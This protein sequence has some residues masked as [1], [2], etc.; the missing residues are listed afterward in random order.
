[1][2][3]NDINVE[4]H[5]YVSVQNRRAVL[6]EMNT[7]RVVMMVINQRRRWLQQHMGAA[8]TNGYCGDGILQTG[9]ACDDGNQNG[10]GDGCSMIAQ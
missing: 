6:A 2:D 3:G 7:R 4:M 1:M 5:V 8:E 10:S 9:E